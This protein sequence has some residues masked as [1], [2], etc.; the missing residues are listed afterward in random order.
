MKAVRNISTGVVSY[1]FDDN[2]LVT[3]TKAGL[4]TP[5]LAIDV[6]PDTHEVV[7]CSMPT[8][9][10]FGGMLSLTESGEWSIIHKNFYDNLFA[11]KTR[12]K[13]NTLLA[14]TDWV[15]V[16]HTERGTNIPLE[17]ET[18]RQDLRDITGHVNFPYLKEGDWPVKP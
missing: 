11:E 18:Y 16:F 2:K 3:L 6:R 17:W 14:E 13:R 9:P 7:E 10:F 5:I 15:V 1:L 12:E 8:V 4:T